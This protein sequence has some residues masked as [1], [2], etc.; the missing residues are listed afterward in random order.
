M[1]VSKYSMLID[2]FYYLCTAIHQQLT[3]IMLIYNFKRVFKARGIDKPR[4]FLIS[5]GFPRGIAT[6]I[7]TNK[8]DRFALKHLEKLCLILNCTPD[9]LLEWKPSDKKEDTP[10]TALYILKKESRQSGT[11][12]LL[13][14]L[15]LSKLE[16]LAKVLREKEE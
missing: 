16:E 1:R 9:D 2:T 7:A 3:G 4:A 10:G 12:E 6:S 5:H 11:E 13:R 8:V 15:P 14:G